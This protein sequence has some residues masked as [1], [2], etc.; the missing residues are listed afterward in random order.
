MHNMFFE[1]KFNF[2]PKPEHFPFLQSVCKVLENIGSGEIIY[3][4]DLRQWKKCSVQARIVQSFN[5]VEGRL[6]VMFEY[7]GEHLISFHCDPPS[8]LEKI[9][10]AHTGERGNHSIIITGVKQAAREFFLEKS[11]SPIF[12]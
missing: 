5:D 11:T 10:N 8:S 7:N 4:N 3:R 9:M 6:S 1:V 2:V 12:S